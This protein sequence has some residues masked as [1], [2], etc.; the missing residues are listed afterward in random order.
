MIL[1]LIPSRLGSTRLKNKALIE[2]DGLPLVVHTLKRA[3]MSKLLDEVIVCTDSLKI[4]KIVEKHGGKF[5]LTKSSHI[6]GTERIAEVAK[7]YKNS[8]L[9]VDI[10]GDE[11]LL[12]PK[13][14]DE[15]IK[16]HRKKIKLFDIIV[17]SIKG[18]N[19][20]SENIVKVVFDKNGKVLY[21]SRAPIPYNYNNN[22]LNLYKHFSI[23]SFKRSSL[24][25]FSKLKM[26]KNEKIEGVELLRA[27]EN[28][29]RL[30][31]FV[32]NSNSFAV[33]IKADLDKAH[34]II[35]NDPIRKKY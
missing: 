6:N 35:P 24:L 29:I 34:Q 3:Q 10:Q 5:Q 11:P 19:L 32:L 23:I 14:I 26:S 2:I 9:I 21:L 22:R 31:T 13:D 8:E 12:D 4:G 1:G 16:F 33:D 15:V 28:N 20:D 7:K 25:K 18:S 30:G 27:V 17:P